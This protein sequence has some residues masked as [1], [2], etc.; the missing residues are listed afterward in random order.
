MHS[1]TLISLALAAVMTTGCLS[2]DD[3]NRRAKIGA[4][5]GAIAGAIIGN[6]VG[7]GSSTNRV[8][9][10]IVGGLAG[11]AVGN[12][13]DKQARELERALEDELRAEYVTL[14]RLDRDTIKL[15]LSSEASFDVDRSV[16]K[17]AFKP[18][19]QRV[20]D[21]M[22]RYDQTVVHVV[23]HTDS[24]GSAAHNQALSERR[25]EAVAAN[26]RSQGVSGNRLYTSG[27]GENEPRAT[28]STAEG[29]KLN[30]RVELFI[31]AVVSGRENDAYRSPY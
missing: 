25:A 15:S 21:V 2:E 13:M 27:R 30:R 31:N 26:L 29:R 12:Y 16:V 28:N 10:A 23:G 3:P 6:N 22:R 4:A 24:T 8:I 5:T 17:S 11:G 19:L 9:G 7:D 14:E 20:A 1:K 18:A